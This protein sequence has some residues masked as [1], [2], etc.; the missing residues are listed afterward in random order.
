MNPDIHTCT[1]L[2]IVPPSLRIVLYFLLTQSPRSSSCMSALFLLSFLQNM[3]CLL[4]PFISDWTAP[5]LSLALRTRS[6]RSWTRSLVVL[7]K[8]QH[9]WSCHVRSVSAFVN[10]TSMDSS[11]AL[12]RGNSTFSTVCLSLLYHSAKSCRLLTY[13]GRKRKKKC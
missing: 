5:Q 4:H 11:S 12:M 13:W 6:K 8:V 2:W 7:M 3:A 1:S 9:S 10:C